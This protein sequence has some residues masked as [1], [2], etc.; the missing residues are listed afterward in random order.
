MTIGRVEFRDVS[1]ANA[2][3]DIARDTMNLSI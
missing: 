1:K 3:C 2:S